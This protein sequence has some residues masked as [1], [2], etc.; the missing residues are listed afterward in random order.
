MPDVRPASADQAA[1]L[2]RARRARPA[3]RDRRPRR[4]R[5]R[6]APSR[7]CAS[8]STALVT[9][10]AR[11]RSARAAALPAGDAAPRPRDGR[12]PEVA[13][14]I[15]PAAIF[16]FEGDESEAAEQDERAEPPRGLERVPG[17]DRA[18][19]HAGR[20]LPGLSGDRRARA[21]A[22][23]RRHRRRRRLLGV[24]PRALGGSGA[25][26]DVPPARDRPHRRARD[27]ARLARRL[28]RARG[29]SC[30]AR[31]AWTSELDVATDPFFGRSGRMLA[32]SQREQELKFEVLVPDRRAGA[33]RASRRSTTTRTTSPRPTGSSSPTAASAHT[34]CLGFGLERITLALLRTHGL[35]A[36]AWPAEVRSE[37]WQRMST[38][39][40]GLVSLLG[41]D[42]RELPAAPAARAR[43]HLRGD[44][45][46]HRH[47]HR[48]AAR[49]RRRAA[50]GA[51]LP[52]CGST[53]R[54]TSGPSSSR[55]PRTSSRCSASTSTR[56]SP[57]GR[58][59]SRSPSRSSAGRT[60]IV[61]L[62]SWYLPDTAATSYRAEH[63][64]TSVAAEAID[65]DARAAALLPRAR[66]LRARR[67]GLPRR[68]PPRPS[69]LRGRAAA[70]HRARALRRR[71][72]ARR[73][74]SCA[75]PRATL[76]R[77]HLARRPASEPVRALRRAARAR[78][79]ALL[80]GDASDYHA[81]AFATV[82]MAGSAF[83]VAGVAGR[84]AARRRRRRARARR[85]ERSST[86]A[87]SS[88]SG[89]PAAARSIR[90]RRSRRWR[91]PGSEAMARLD[92]VARLSTPLQQ[93]CR[94]HARA[95]TVTTRSLLGDG[96]QAAPCAPG[97]CTPTPT[98]L[99]ALDVACPRA[100]R[101]PRRQRCATRAAGAPAIRATLD[102]EDWWFRT[103]FD[104]AAGCSR[105]KRC[106]SAS[107]GSRRSPRSTSTASCVLESDSMFARSRARC[108][109]AAASAQRAR[110]LLPRA[111]PAAAACAAARARA[112]ARG[113]SPTATC[114]SSAR[115]CSAA[116]RGSRPGRRR[117]GPGGRCGSSAAGGSRSTELDAAPAAATATT[118]CCAVRALL[119]SLDGELAQRRR[120]SS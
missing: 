51:G 55:R 44:Q 69:V 91:A 52:P 68:L 82:R 60:L 114:A 61:E 4:L 16:A 112:G 74:T 63:V 37:L 27:G 71:R 81:Y 107:T 25:P 18:R 22:S 86:A 29:S 108:R 19:A 106:A 109:G 89:S 73:A 88:P 95:S 66:P 20:L 40:T 79:A 80:E 85:C 47:P 70:L 6:R 92:D 24:P 23:R 32:A 113:W 14:R 45:L 21:A 65:L 62:D 50:G 26:A 36:D 11:A 41:L 3:D 48:A 99:D 31:S 58:C 77:G 75:R 87:R 54:A 38:A 97:R 35:D 111:R 30:C 33:D 72:R 5:P 12:L 28:A 98:A 49:P 90:S 94:P 101:A 13:S 59:P 53:S 17:H 118:A 100:C 96:W 9:R 120:A 67:R 119:R 83:E 42:P 115:C 117:S 64:K 116:A 8:A 105:A 15:S 39:A 2:A 110:D 46:L 57:T 78:P 7:T 10:A 43:A 34:A 93:P 56:C 102:A 1:L 84:L 103:S 76:L 104:A